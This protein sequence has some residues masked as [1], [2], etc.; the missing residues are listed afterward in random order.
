MH[1]ESP[2]AAAATTATANRAAGPAA[3]IRDV[4][5]LKKIAAR[6]RLQVV[7]MVAPTGQGYVQQG[8]GAADIF[9]ALYF[10]EA[11]LDPAAPDW[12]ARDRIFL[13][14]AH[15]TAVFYA[16]L[17]ARGIIDAALLP[18]YCRDD[19]PL[20]INASE[21]LG[22]CV[23]ATCGS[24][25]QGA[26]VALGGAVAARRRGSA[27]RVFAILGDGEL[28]EGQVW[29][30]VMAAAGWGVDNLCFVLDYN[31][32]QS[33]GAMDAVL[34]VAPVAAKFE[35]FGWAVREVDGHDLAALL[36]A[37]DAARATTGAPSCIIARTIPGRGVAAL[38]GVMAHQL[39]LAPAVAAA[40]RAE[41]ME[42][43]S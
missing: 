27:A 15:N 38:E 33:E 41:L 35:A 4:A 2:A 14:T 3:R 42:G 6:I 7:E 12:P 16:T 40:A 36:A 43:A 21:R 1:A 19:S 9:T 28:Q 8:L 31:R 17:A 39:R 11:R 29:E 23:E 13:T 30:A 25:G 5:A 24:L 34:P 26:S 22:A 18:T 37:F 32:M 10:A 20:E